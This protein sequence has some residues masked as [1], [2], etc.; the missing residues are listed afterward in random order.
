MAHSAVCCQLKDGISGVRL[1][2]SPHP[3]SKPVQSTY[4]VYRFSE[5]WYC[6]GEVRRTALKFSSRRTALKFSC[7]HNG[8]RDNTSS[9]GWVPE[10]VTETWDNL[11]T[12]SIR[13]LIAQTVSLGTCC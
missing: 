12:M 8:V 11:R 6:A 10:F 9:M 13:Q 3:Q 2:P 4:Q 7:Y 1:Q 5:L